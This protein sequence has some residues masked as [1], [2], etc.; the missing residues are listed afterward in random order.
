MSKKGGTIGIQVIRGEDFAKT[1]RAADK[2]E[3]KAQEFLR[4]FA[5]WSQLVNEYPEIEPRCFSCA[6]V[7]RH[8][9]D[10]GN[11]GGLA[12]GWIKH[13]DEMPDEAVSYACPFCIDCEPRGRKKLC[14]AFG[15]RMAEELGLVGLSSMQ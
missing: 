15:D 9:G 6:A 11:F 2:G 4:A 8:V 5:K 1:G 3:R 13:E 7:V 14:K 12:V 10:D